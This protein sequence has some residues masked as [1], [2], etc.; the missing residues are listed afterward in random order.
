MGPPESA[1]HGV[2][3][4]ARFLRYVFWVVILTWLVRRLQ[5]WLF[6]PQTPRLVSPGTPVSNPLFRDPVCGTHVSP[7]ISYTLEQG[8]QI[9]HFC[10][11]ECREH[12]RVTQRRAAGG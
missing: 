6:P 2:G 9:L 1:E 7:E 12:Y 4:L 8:G 10:S 11:A 5:Q 3:F